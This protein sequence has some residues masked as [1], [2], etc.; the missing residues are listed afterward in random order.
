MGAVQGIGQGLLAAIQRKMDQ[1][2][3]EKQNPQVD[4][5]SMLP[6]EVRQRLYPETDSL[7]VPSSAASHMFTQAM[8]LYGQLSKPV[9][10]THTLPGDFFATLAEAAAS[11]DWSRF[12]ELYGEQQ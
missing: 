7:M 2:W 11:G 5:L 8:G 4:F 1:D 9:Q 6:P 3:Y 10:D 12:R